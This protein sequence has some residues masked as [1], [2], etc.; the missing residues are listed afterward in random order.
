MGKH[1]ELL[2]RVKAAT[3]PDRQLDADVLAACGYRVN[4]LQRNRWR[5]W[6]D[7]QWASM[8][9]ISASI[10]A[11]KALV[12]R[13]LPG[14]FWMLAKGRAS[15]AEPMFGCYLLFGTEEVIGDGEA[16]TAPLAILVALLTTL[17][18]RPE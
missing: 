2:E 7:G 18:G 3:G 5:V 15:E 14:V 9:E 10:D 4:D 6:L 17:E 8:P 11:A 13:V 12:E 1:T 16:A